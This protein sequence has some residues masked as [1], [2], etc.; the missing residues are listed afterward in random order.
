VVNPP[1]TRFRATTRTS[2]SSA[3]ALQRGGVDADPGQARTAGIAAGERKDTTG[4]TD[5]V[6]HRLSRGYSACALG[7]I[8]TCFS[9]GAV[10]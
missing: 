6:L 8:S 1:R 3:R 10:S 9:G 4:V 5:L 7:G 2:A